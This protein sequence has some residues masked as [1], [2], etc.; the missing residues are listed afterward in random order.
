MGGASGRPRPLVLIGGPTGS[1]KSALASAASRAEGGVVVN[2]DSAQVYR[3]LRI[4]TAR[5]SPEDE[6]ATPHRLYGVLP[7]ADRCSV[8]RWLDMADAEIDAAEAA[9]RVPIVVGGTGLYLKALTEGLSPIPAIPADVR[10]EAEALYMRLGGAGFREALAGRDPAAAKRLP[11]G[12][13]QRLIRAWEVVEATGHPLADWHRRQPAKHGTPRRSTLCIVL[14]PPRDTLY[15][16]LDS[17]F[18]GMLAAGALDEVADLMALGLDPG[19]PAMKSVGVRELAR[20]LTG[21]WTLA[22]ATAAAQQS[23]RRL[24]KR[25]TTWL[26]HQMQPALTIREQYSER[27]R[28]EILSFIR[29][30]LLTPD[31]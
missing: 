5:P 24:A 31:N 13:R 27:L 1:G 3:E 20:C 23:T 28:D 30:S 11:D 21:E 6:A 10:A 12:D 29:R 18:E 17:R 26:R 16:A 2:A 8:A 7:A 22:S 25:Q 19:L 15:A 4:L 14:L 9:G